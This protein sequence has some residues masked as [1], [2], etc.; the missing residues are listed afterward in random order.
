MYKLSGF[1]LFMALV[2]LASSTTTSAKQCTRVCIAHCSGAAYVRFGPVYRC[3][4]DLPTCKRTGN[5]RHPWSV[6][7]RK[8]DYRACNAPRRRNLF[9]DWARDE[10]EDENVGD[11]RVGI[12]FTHKWDEMDEAPVDENFDDENVGDYRVGIEFTHKWDEM[13]QRR[14]LPTKKRL[15]SRYLQVR[16]NPNNFESMNRKYKRSRRLAPAWYKV[17]KFLV[18]EDLKRCTACGGLCEEQFRHKYN[19]MCYCVPNE[20]CMARCRAGG[21]CH[22]RQY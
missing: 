1:V 16:Q 14:R 8:N 3:R 7:G 9:P 2:M 18:K 12:E 10:I 19:K 20:Q 4:E 6:S 5:S 22:V 15:L 11:Y 17:L 21:A 13:D